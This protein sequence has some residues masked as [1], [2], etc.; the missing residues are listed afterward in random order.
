MP[1]SPLNI[2]T[3]LGFYKGG[4]SKTDPSRKYR[5]LQSLIQSINNVTRYYAERRDKAKKQ[6][7][8]DAKFQ[9]GKK[10]GILDFGGKFIE[11]YGDRFSPEQLNSMIAD[12]NAGTF[13]IPEYTKEPA[14]GPVTE[15]QLR[16]GI[17]QPTARVPF[18]LESPLAYF[19][20]DTQ[21]L[22]VL[23]GNVSKKNVIVGKENTGKESPAQEAW[24]QTL[25][26]ATEAMNTG[27]LTPEMEN[28]AVDAARNLGVNPDIYR[29][30][31]T[32]TETETPSS[33]FDFG[34]I[35]RNVSG[36]FL[37]GASS[38]GKGFKGGAKAI[39][40]AG[41]KVMEQTGDLFSIQGG[42]TEQ[43]VK[44]EY[45]DAFKLTDGTWA[46]RRNGVVSRIRTQ[47]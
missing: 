33:N 28:A 31:R 32:Q 47:K 27:A 11:K 12:I 45:P 5:G 30:K 38:I 13:R 22:K 19:D 34:A 40:R 4:G 8:E 9:L 44:A 20:P 17:T 25:K 39:S 41:G 15:E 29:I 18:S 26:A 2:L 24:L 3:Q 43:T 37:S 42:V 14:A 36:K 16:A 46:V 7:L 10:K 1:E 35:L 23:P 21:E 6:E